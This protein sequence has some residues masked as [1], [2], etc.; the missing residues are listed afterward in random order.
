MLMRFDSTDV[1][2]FYV[3][4]GTALLVVWAMVM[5]VMELRR[6]GRRAAMWHDDPPV[7]LTHHPHA[8]RRARHDRCTPQRGAGARA[9]GA[10]NRRSQTV[11][12]G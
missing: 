6:A 10:P 2:L 9:S 1:A 4:M 8:A 12:S 5:F 3:C 11:P 7:P